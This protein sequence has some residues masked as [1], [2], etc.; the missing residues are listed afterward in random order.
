MKSNT[1]SHQELLIDFVVTRSSLLAQT[2]LVL[3]GSLLLTISAKTMI[4]IGP[5]PLTLQTLTVLLL[6][7][8]LGRKLGT[9]VVLTY[10][11]QGFCGLPVFAGPF[12]GATF[13]YL[14]G[15]IPAVWIAGYAAEHKK[16]RRFVTALPYLAVAHQTIFL[17]GILWLT[18]LLGSFEQAFCVGYL[19]FFGADIAKFVLA[20]AIVSTLW[21]RNKRNTTWA[22]KKRDIPD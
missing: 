19:P 18:F 14:L 2:L 8:S 12:A 16:D 3:G 11:A 9:L 22:S 13:G 15:M 10:L 4:P 21:K 7:A 6:G 20:S 1:L 17:G 5:V